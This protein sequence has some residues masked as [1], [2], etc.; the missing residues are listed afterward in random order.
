MGGI[1]MT[2]IQKVESMS[3]GIVVLDN[4]IESLESA[5]Q[6]RNIRVVIPPAGMPDNQ[7]IEKLLPY[8]I[9]ITNNVRHFTSDAS[10]FEYG[11][12]EVPMA[13]MADPVNAAKMIS[14]A[15]SQ[16]ALWSKKHGFLVTLSLS[17]KATYKEIID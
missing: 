14:D 16:Y 15:I 11:I 4:N 8:R 2:F 5:L 10:S 6:K 3:R 13:A 12:I 7:I 9:F 17:N 1:D